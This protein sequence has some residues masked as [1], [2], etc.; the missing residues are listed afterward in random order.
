MKKLTMVLVLAGALATPHAQT[1]TEILVVTPTNTRGWTTAD[2]RPGGSVSLVQDA[3]PPRGSGALQLTT[4]S[5]TA[6]KAQF[7]HA[8]NTALALVTDLSYWTKQNSVAVPISA[9]SYQL[10]VNLCAT[11]NPLNPNGFTTFVFEP[12]QSG[13]PVTTVTP[14][15]WQS[16]DVAAG[17]MWSSRSV[18]CGSESVVAGAGGPPFYTLADLQARFPAAV[19]VGF[20]VNIGTFNPS[21]DVLSDLVQFNETIYDFELYSTATD[22]EECKKGGWSTF[23]PPTGPYKNQ[24]QCVSAAV[25]Q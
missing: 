15:V 1:A 4:D 12:Y 7:M 5:T 24:G 17:Q 3:T 10:A 16:W 6:A 8:T 20:G 2:T 22:P 25:P 23:N 13:L 21:Y 18:T 11:T 19:V 14:G 9:P